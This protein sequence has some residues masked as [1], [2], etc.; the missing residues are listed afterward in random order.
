MSD[1]HHDVVS[2]EVG[3][4]VVGQRHPTTGLK[5]TAGAATFG[6]SAS[7]PLRIELD[8]CGRTQ[9][10]GVL[11]GTPV[12][13]RGQIGVDDR[14][15]KGLPIDSIGAFG[16]RYFTEGIQ[17]S[18]DIVASSD[19]APRTHPFRRREA[20][21]V[22]LLMRER[23]SIDAREFEVERPIDRK[24]VTRAVPEHDDV[25]CPLIRR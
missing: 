24:A 25:S 17:R 10:R 18:S 13:M 7:C 16:E 1:P 23:P 5:L 4:R 22:S 21:H 19:D 12:R 8:R 3:N 2:V 15:L 11:A 9:A 6:D 14:L 20:L